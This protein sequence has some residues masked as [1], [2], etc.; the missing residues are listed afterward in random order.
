ML[1]CVLIFIIILWMRKWKFIEGEL[2]WPSC[3]RLSFVWQSSMTKLHHVYFCLFNCCCPNDFFCIVEDS[4]M[5]ALILQKLLFYAVQ[6]SNNRRIVLKIKKKYAVLYL[7]LLA[8]TPMACIANINFNIT[9]SLWE[10]K[11]YI[12]YK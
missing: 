3:G 9:H 10:G 8:R 1:T 5:V 2:I 4:A 12:W 6:Y 7:L 11:N